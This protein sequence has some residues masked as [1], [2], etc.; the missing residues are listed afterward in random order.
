[1]PDFCSVCPPFKT[2][3]TPLTFR[4]EN[5]ALPPP[6]LKFFVGSGPAEKKTQLNKGD[7]ALYQTG[8]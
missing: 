2:L 5:P 6:L 1:M 7:D 4:C 8:V 3:A